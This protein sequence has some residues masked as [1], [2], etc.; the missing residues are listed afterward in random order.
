[1]EG[2]IGNFVGHGSTTIVLSSLTPY[3]RVCRFFFQLNLLPHYS[4]CS[5]RDNPQKRKPAFQQ[6]SNWPLPVFLIVAESGPRFK[7][8]VW[9]SDD[10]TFCGG[11]KKVATALS[12]KKKRD[13]KN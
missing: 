9:A 8:T 2:N 1:M 4:L 5:Q 10:Q 3:A 12:T 6:F 13:Y 11:Q 7:M